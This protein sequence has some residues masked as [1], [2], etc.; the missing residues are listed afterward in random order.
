MADETTTMTTTTETTDTTDYKALYEKSKAANDKLS[1]EN[2]AYKRREREQMDE[3]ARAAADL[4]EERAQAKRDREELAMLKIGGKLS[5]HFKD[6][7][8][9][10]KIATLLVGGKID[11][12]LDVMNEYLTKYHADMRKTIEDEL[13]ADNPEASP[14]GQSGAVTKA[15]ILAIAD[16]EERQRMIAKHIHLFT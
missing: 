15:S 12:A 10:N 9:A 4:E 8:T 3:Q 13:M 1:S 14:Q 6:A 7:K 11:E 2:A 5:T 16:Y